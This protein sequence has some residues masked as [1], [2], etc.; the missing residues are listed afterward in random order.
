MEATH[1]AISLPEEYKY[2][3]CL[4]AAIAFHCLMVGFVIAGGKRSKIFNKE[5]MSQFEKEHNREMHQSMKPGGYP[6]MGNGIYADKLSYKDWFEFNL[7]QRCHKNYLESL[8]I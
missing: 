6:D 8:T 2:V 5:F 3:V 4:T 7:D 1:I